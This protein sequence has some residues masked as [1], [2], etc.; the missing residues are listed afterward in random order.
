MICFLNISNYRY[1]SFFSIKREIRLK[2]AFML[3]DVKYFSLQSRC[4]SCLHSSVVTTIHAYITRSCSLLSCYLYT[5]MKP[6]KSL[7]DAF[8]ANRPRSL[9]AGRGQ[10][11]R[12]SNATL[13]SFISGIKQH[14]ATAGEWWANM[15]PSFSSFSHLKATRGELMREEN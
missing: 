12:N 5:W 8:R 11:N 10:K 1:R 14:R 13:A 4:L 9:A 3:T 7:P 6:T 2:I 15:N